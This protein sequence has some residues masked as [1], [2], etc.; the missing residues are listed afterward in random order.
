MNDRI[1]WNFAPDEE[2]SEQS[3][4]SMLLE[5]SAWIT[6]GSESEEGKPAARNLPF[7]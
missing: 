5:L 7:S 2:E 3:G 4:S 6:K 1:R